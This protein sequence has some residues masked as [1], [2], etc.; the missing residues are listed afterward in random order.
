MKTRPISALLLGLALIAHSALAGELLYYGE[1]ALPDPA[2]VARILNP[3]LARAPATKVRALRLLDKAAPAP[4][5]RPAESEPYAPGPAAATG[6]SA[7]SAF[8]LPLPFLADS[9]RLSAETAA[10]LD[11]VA[12]GIRMAGPNVRIVIEG[13]TDASGNPEHNIMLSIRRASTIKTYL[14]RRHG[15]LPDALV[16]AGLGST[17]PLNARNPRAA[18]NRRVEFR[19]EMV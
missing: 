19:A 16:V 4:A 11:A 5:A 6:A 13:H 9:A 1:H 12:E 2:Q 7:Y 15:I 8:A 17:Q 3:A 10:Q 18:E 14:V